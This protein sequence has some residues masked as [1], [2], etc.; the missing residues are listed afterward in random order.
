MT[1]KNYK[2]E[3]DGLRALAVL[4][5]LLFH[6]Q[7]PGFTGGFVGVDV[8]FVI[9]GWL[10]TRLIYTE[11]QQRS[12]SIVNFYV[13][14]VRRIL[15]A[16]F[17]TLLV[18]A[19]FGALILPPAE[20]ERLLRSAIYGGLALSNVLFWRESGYFDS[21]AIYKPLLHTWTLGVEEQFYL[22]WPA[23]VLG[24]LW[25]PNKW[26]SFAGL[27]VMGGIS[28][29]LAEYVIDGDAAGAFYLMPFRVI[30]F[31]IG[32]LLVWTSGRAVP[33]E[34]WKEVYCVIG[35]ALIAAAVFWYSPE[36][37]F[38]GVAALVPCVGAAL[39][40]LGGGATYS[41]YALRN[42]LSVWIGRISYSLYLVHWPTL[43]LYYQ[44][45]L[46]PL[47]RS[48]QAGIVIFSV[49][50]ASVMFC[51]IEQPFRYGR[52]ATAPLKVFGT[53]S[54]CLALLLRLFR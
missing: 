35:L 16:L 25:T 31:V 23:T 37:R 24:L 6:L 36:T 1:G 7:V 45:K 50:L 5:V 29:C 10:I 3:I 27:L 51:F 4:A 30:E 52:P 22:L 43:S 46:E 54:V 13:R 26:I 32:A 47:S 49:A 34:A 42:P 48:E 53:S 41:G 33:S 15:P 18:T 20:L 14:R 2:P 21:D 44:W 8:F 12:F 39:L 17:V 19:V 11:A 28:L 40:I 38:P 9:S